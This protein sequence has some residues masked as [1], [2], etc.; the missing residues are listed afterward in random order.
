VGCETEDQMIEFEFDD[1]LDEDHVDDESG[2]DLR[3]Y[4]ELVY[5]SEMDTET[6]DFPV[7]D[8]PTQ[9]EYHNKTFKRIGCLAHL[10]QLAIKDALWEKGIVK[11]TVKKIGDIV[12]YFHKSDKWYMNLRK[13]IGGLSLVK[14]C[15]TRWNS[16]YHSLK[17]IIGEHREKVSSI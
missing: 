13:R 3:D 6:E 1:D 11:N 7:E 9:I 16:L 10:I 8:I 5:D 12:K 17:R 2:I 14:P 15:A 4:L